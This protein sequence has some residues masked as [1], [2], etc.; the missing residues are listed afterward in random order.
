VPSQC[1]W[2]QR[3]SK[4]NDDLILAMLREDYLARCGIEVPDYKHFR[5]PNHFMRVLTQDF[6]NMRDFALDKRFV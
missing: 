3:A 4:V 2:R 1:F 5:V 6:A